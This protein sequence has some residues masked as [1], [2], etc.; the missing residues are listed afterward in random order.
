[1]D[2]P[3]GTGPLPIYQLGEGTTDPVML[4]GSQLEGHIFDFGKF[5]FFNQVS[6]QPNRD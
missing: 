5:D 4:T 6:D 1:M 3:V 2:G